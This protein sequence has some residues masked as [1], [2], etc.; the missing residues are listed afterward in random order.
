VTVRVARVEDARAIGHTLA[1]AF[2]DDPVW[3]WLVPR[4]RRWRRGVPY[5]FTHA[6]RQHLGDET[7]WVTP[8]LGAAAVW[9][10]PGHHH[11][12][13][14]DLPAVP[15]SL[16]VFTRRSPAGLRYQAEMRRNRP[17][18]RHWYLAILGADP[19]YQ[20]RGYGSAVLQPALDRCDDEG[21]G[22]YLESSK[23]TNLAYYR[24]FGFELRR[25]LR[26]VDAA[27]PIWLMWRDPR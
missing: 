4:A 26:P 2:H 15:R 27:P 18:E 21:L 25:E 3:L 17:E 14:A 5:V 7:V 20:G 22:A 12:R 1:R 24:R 6:T 23:E 8:D 11:S 10:P 13:L 16:A 19:V 9:S